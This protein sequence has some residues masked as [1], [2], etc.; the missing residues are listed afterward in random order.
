M[1]PHQD[2]VT[3][4]TLFQPDGADCAYH[5]LMSPPSF[6]SHRRRQARLKLLKIHLMNIRD[7]GTDFGQGSPVVNK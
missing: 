1:G 4:L 2:L 3:T 5:I 7:D 6:E